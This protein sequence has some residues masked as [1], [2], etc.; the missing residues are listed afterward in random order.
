MT[1]EQTKEKA[2]YWVTE[3]KERYGLEN[4]LPCD[5]LL[6]HL[7]VLDMI[8]LA[9]DVELMTELVAAHG[10]DSLKPCVCDAL[11]YI[12]D[13]SKNECYKTLRMTKD[14]NVQNCLKIKKEMLSSMMAPLLEK[15]EKD[16]NGNGTE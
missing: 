6:K 12:V 16:Q 5:F 9:D 7:T 14:V 1:A 4:V 8:I 13:L 15:T 10:P 2:K 3:I 11:T